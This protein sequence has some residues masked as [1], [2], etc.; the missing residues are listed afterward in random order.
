[1]LASNEAFASFVPVPLVKR[2]ASPSTATS[3]SSDPI[4]AVPLLMSLLIA[5]D[6]WVLEKGS[7]STPTLLLAIPHG[8]VT[9]AHG[10]PSE[11]T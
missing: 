4:I 2:R 1:M 8:R 7:G 11:M 5:S 3:G 10:L 6:Q 9:Q